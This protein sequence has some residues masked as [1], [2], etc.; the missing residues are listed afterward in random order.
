MGKHMLVIWTNGEAWAQMSEEEQQGLFAEYFQYTQ[1]LMDK[2]WFVVGDPLLPVAKTVRVR[3]GETQI[4]DGPYAETKEFLGGYYEI[5][6]T[7]DEALEAAARLPDAR[8]GAV[9][10]HPVQE[11]ELPEGMSLP[12]PSGE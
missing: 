9:S 1:W 3:D 12:A 11:L 4:T 7:D 5:D 10:V 2:G 6:C 8:Y